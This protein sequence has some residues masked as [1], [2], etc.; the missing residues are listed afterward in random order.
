MTFL[1]LIIIKWLLFIISFAHTLTNIIIHNMIQV[2][3]LLLYIL[4]SVQF[5]A[6]AQSDNSYRTDSL[7]VDSLIKKSYKYKYSNFDSATLIIDKAINIAQDKELIRQEIYAFRVK[8]IIYTIVG[9]LDSSIIIYKKALETAEINELTDLYSRIY[10]NIGVAYAKKGDFPDAKTYY[11][12]A[13]NDSILEVDN[14]TKANVYGNLGLMYNA[15]GEYYNAMDVQIK[16]LE[17]WE[18]INDTSK[19]AAVILNIANVYFYQKDYANAIDFYKRALKLNIQV[20][21]L[22]REGQC[23]HNLG[24]IYQKL[25]SLELANK[26]LNLALNSKATRTSKGKAMVYNMLGLVALKENNYTKS[27]DYFD[28]TY[29]IYKSIN[30][31]YIMIPVLNNYAV[32]YNQMGQS[33][34]SLKYSFKA[35]VLAKE[36]GYKKYEK[37]V[38]LNISESYEQIG[39][40]SKSLKYYKEYNS[41]N[42]SLFN[43]G[44]YSQIQELQ[45][46]YETAK[47]ESKLLEQTALIENSK[48]ESIAK[49]ALLAKE[50]S[51]KYIITLIF[52]LF[53]L[54]FAVI[55]YNLRQKRKST[56]LLIEKNEEIGNRKI[57][58]LIKQHQLNSI[59]D[60][61]DVQRDE[62][63]RIAQELHDGI[64][65]SL[66]AIKLYIG[67]LLKEIKVEGLDLIHDNI[68]RV[69]KEVRT[70]SHNLTPAEFEL[71]SITDIVQDYVNQISQHSKTEFILIA[72]STYDWN[73]IDEKLQVNIYRIVQELINNIIKHAQATKVEIKL[74]INESEIK[75]EVVDNGKGFDVKSS[76]NGIGVRNMKT[77]ISNF[78]GNIEFNSTIGKG[79]SVVLKMPYTI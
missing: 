42:D 47:K 43:K 51:Q 29:K 64:G 66:A 35:L 19:I 14:K 16:A 34:V 2:K 21:N 9:K 69:Y 57:S 7:E 53:V 37:D 18:S 45:V 38:Y 55:I 23:Y 5:L 22:Y 4:L 20:S 72:N 58:E 60:K 79:T 3:H 17:Y 39:K 50:K 13:L 76:A 11:F 62:R 56:L 33:A 28:K 15:K 63:H 74:N 48:L 46:K 73:K 10:I 65:G 26:Y 31:K 54:V 78:G 1:F 27:K 70:I 68:D 41:L 8:G 71:T 75:I 52:G 49:D 40:Y 30:S 32:L 24:T 36:S 59:K 44:K 6:F 61:L 25:D 77:R 67:S 12:K